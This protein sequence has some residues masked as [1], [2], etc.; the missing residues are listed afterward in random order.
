MPCRCSGVGLGRST[1]ILAIVVRTTFM[2][3]RLAPATVRPIGTPFASVN[4]LRFT[5]ALPRSVGF[6]P[7]FFPTQRRFGHRAVHAQP[8]PV[9]PLHFVIL[10][11]PGLPELQEHTGV[12]PGLKPQMRGGAR[13]KTRLIQGFPL[14]PRPQHIED[15]IGAFAVGHPWS[16]PTK[17]VRV[18]VLR[19]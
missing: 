1:G 9:Y 16:A 8:C 15:A 6:G 7:V 3:L 17:T 12:H 5:P 14:T 4:T 2:S 19:N 18:Y 10:L 13:A 11:Q